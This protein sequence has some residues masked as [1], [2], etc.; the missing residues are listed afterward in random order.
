[1]MKMPLKFAKPI[2]LK[3]VCGFDQIGILVGRLGHWILREPSRVGFM[4]KTVLRTFG[5]Y[6]T[7]LN[8]N[9]KFSFKTVVCSGVIEVRCFISN[10]KK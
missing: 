5:K 3:N 10:Y 8:G 7:V 4:Q 6:N 9:S 2:Y 1:M